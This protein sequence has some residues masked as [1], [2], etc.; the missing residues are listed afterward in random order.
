[1]RHLHRTAELSQNCRDVPST[2]IRTRQWL[3]FIPQTVQHKSY[4]L[5]ISSYL[6]HH[7]MWLSSHPHP[8]QRMGCTHSEPSPL[9]TFPPATIT[10]DQAPAPSQ[11]HVSPSTHSPTSWDSTVPLE[12]VTAALLLWA[13]LLSS[14]MLG[15]SILAG[16]SPQAAC[17]VTCI[18]HQ[19]P[20]LE[21]PSQIHPSRTAIAQ[22]REERYSIE[23]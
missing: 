11:L 22:C 16:S 2:P 21:Q 17:P 23:K 15:T 20:D 3:T 10:H 1:M 6:M 9:G 18:L 14:S 4:L 8:L 7:G 5:P 19:S 13:G 12:M